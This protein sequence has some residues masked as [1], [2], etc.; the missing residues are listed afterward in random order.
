MV[1][2]GTLLCIAVIPLFQPSN[3]IIETIFFL[4]LYAFLGLSWNMLAG[5]AG[6]F[7]LGHAAFFGVG[8]YTAGILYMKYRITPWAAMLVGPA[9]ASCLAWTVGY[10]TFKL[11]RHYYALATL[12]MAEVMR[13]GFLSWDYVG[14]AYGIW[15]DVVPFSWIALQFSTTHVP[16][17]YLAFVA[18]CG[19]L[20]LTW[21]IR[22]SEFGLRLMAIR[23]DEEGAKA[24]GIDTLSHKL[25]IS[26]L[27]AA[28]A[29]VGGV[30]YAQYSLFL[31]PDSTLSLLVTADMV[32]PTLLG[33]LGTTYGPILGALILEPLTWVL[34]SLVGSSLQVVFRGILLILIVLMIPDGL[35]KM[36]V[37]RYV[38]P[39]L[40]R[41]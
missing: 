38:R 14:A 16:Y 13:L 24:L 23:D 37:D 15:Y 41:K 20:L 19:G 11:R 10:P 35:V 28:L 34:R 36:L 1:V 12:A 7:S 31:E 21:K 32:L 9:L 8:A 6:Q 5:F 29:A 25:K 33:G 39:T 4:L 2:F 18:L 22:K 40:V 27:S 3:V 30:L 26:A 17:Y